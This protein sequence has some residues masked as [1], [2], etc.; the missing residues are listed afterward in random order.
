MTYKA[1]SAE[2][3]ELHLTFNKVAKTMM[4][5]FD[6]EKCSEEKMLLNLA[7]T[8]NVFDEFG[9]AREQSVCLANIGGIMQKKGDLDTANLCYEESTR[10]LQEQINKSQ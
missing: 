3:N 6:G 9:N 5:K 10:I 4:N 7:D 8:Y 1:A 2:V